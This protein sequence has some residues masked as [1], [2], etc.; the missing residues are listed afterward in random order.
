MPTER[1][2]RRLARGYFRA[3]RTLPLEGMAL[4]QIDDAPETLS[5][6]L[7]LQALPA[8]AVV[9]ALID[10]IRDGRRF[11]GSRMGV[12]WILVSALGEEPDGLLDFRFLSDELT[13]RADDVLRALAVEKELAFDTGYVFVFLKRSRR[14]PGDIEGLPAL[15][16]AALER[17]QHREDGNY[18]TWL[19]T[20]VQI[21]EI[22]PE[23]PAVVDAIPGV[24]ERLRAYW[25]A[26]VGST[27]GVI[28]VV[29]SIRARRRDDG[30]SSV[31]QQIQQDC[32]EILQNLGRMGPAA[33]NAL[34][35]LREI[36]AAE[37]PNTKPFEKVTQA[38]R[39][40][41]KQAVAEAIAKIEAPPKPKPSALPGESSTKSA[42]P[43]FD[44]VEYSRWMKMLD[45]ERK[46]E[47]LAAAMDACSRLAAAADGPRIA[48]GVFR[49]AK[50]FEAADSREQDQ[51][52]SAGW[53][54]LN[55]LPPLAV[56]D[57][58][59][60]V[61]RD[62]SDASRRKFEAR[63]AA[64]RMAGSIV[65]GSK[66]RA[67]KL[68]AELIK[69]A[70]ENEGG[71]GWFIAGASTVWRHSDRPLKDFEGL[72]PLILGTIENGF[73]VKIQG[74]NEIVPREWMIVA[75]NLVET[76][77]ET[78]D[79]AMMLMKHARASY[80]VLGLIG[81]LGRNAEPIV[82][83]LVD[84][85][86]ARWKRYEHEIREE[87]KL[88]DVNVNDRPQQSSDERILAH[89][90]RVLPLKALGEIGVGPKGYELLR[91]LKAISPPRREWNND[92]A[93]LPALFEAVDEA[94]ARFSPPAE[95]VAM[96]ALLDDF[97]F[98]GGKWKL[99]ALFPGEGPQGIIA[100]IRKTY[101]SW[102]AQSP[103][104]HAV[105]NTTGAPSSSQQFEIDET[106][107]PKQITLVYKQE[108]N[109][110]S[111]RA[112]GIYELT[113]KH[114]KI[115]LA[116]SAGARPKEFSPDKANLPEGRVVL[117]FD[118]EPPAERNRAATGT[119]N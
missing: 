5:A 112:E 96:P 88:D 35:L 71:A 7:A 43:T 117:E 110:P 89:Y 82:P 42:E 105:L 64:E 83:L 31:N 24:V 36:A 102:D 51:V 25:E 100:E 66:S 32:P 58:L 29:T 91:E 95:P 14:K 80:T 57:E 8:P 97:W 108:R 77:P 27:D 10:E 17:A 26:T 107:S 6:I 37:W 54:A 79:L 101:F 93:A 70:A 119:N 50:L 72:K 56:V 59:I 106:Q 28:R 104:V 61:L 49:A 39:D 69:L 103:D 2:A 13:R 44:G 48:H 15:L 98:I 113:E 115:E 4:E 52:F 18:L 47:K 12:G 111:Y 92:A 85:F 90:R 73:S 65:K 34:P 68:V 86:L 41:F 30:G 94:F 1:D 81:K 109:V 21:A 16:T 62:G 99:Q 75:T 22:D 11:V 40:Q 78:P 46:P 116:R 19:A 87:A 45:T 38:Q 114:L 60:F 118:R 9:D 33:R 53:T 3:L 76:A 55:R 63:F 20:L 84:Q 67:P 23:F 74:S